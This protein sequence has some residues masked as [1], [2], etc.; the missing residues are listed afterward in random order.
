MMMFFSA[1]PCVS[2]SMATPASATHLPISG[3]TASSP[4]PAKS[5]HHEPMSKTASSG[6][7]LFQMIE[8]FTAMP[9]TRCTAPTPSERMRKFI[10]L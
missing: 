8:N 9:A 10:G 4:S 2:T 5:T 6:L 1:R 3:F 7:P